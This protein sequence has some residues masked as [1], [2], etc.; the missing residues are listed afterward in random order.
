MEG[1]M[2]TCQNKVSYFVPNGRFAAT[3][4]SVADDYREVFVLCGN[5]DP[6]GAR[7][8]CETCASNPQVMQ[9]I[10]RHEETVAEDNAWLRSAGWGEI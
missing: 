3:F 2:T 4:T 10:M 1:Y 5:T 6:H 8:I 7:A 9:E